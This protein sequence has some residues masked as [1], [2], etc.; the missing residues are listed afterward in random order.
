MMQENRISNKILL[1]SSFS[2]LASVKPRAQLRS[3]KVPHY[4]LWGGLCISKGGQRNG[5]KPNAYYYAY[6]VVSLDEELPGQSC[7]FDPV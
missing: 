6:S 2:V 4:R 1:R 7:H 3:L 5:E